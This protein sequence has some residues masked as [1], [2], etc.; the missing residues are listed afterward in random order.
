ML[1][2]IQFIGDNR[3][4]DETNNSVSQQENLDDTSQYIEAIKEMKANSVSK[5]AYDKLREENKQLLD[6]LING[7]EIEIPK[8]REPVDI[9]KIRSKLFDEDRPLSN[10]EYVSNAL[11]LRDALL[12]RG[13]R[14][15]FLP[16]GQN[17]SPTDEDITKAERV[18]T[19]MKECI[20]YADGDSEL[21]TNELMRRTNDA[22][23]AKSAEIARRQ[24]RKGR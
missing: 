22:M 1:Q 7:K 24:S 23:P 8:Q 15:P 21:F 14:D 16:Y 17:I 10:L 18:A 2:Q 9:D 20:E 11:K 5:Q 19:V 3:M 6:S 13:E 12:E 4:A